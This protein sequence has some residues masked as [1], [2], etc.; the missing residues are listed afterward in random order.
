MGHAPPVP[1]RSMVS[2]TNPNPGHVRPVNHIPPSR[3]HSTSHLP[4]SSQAPPLHSMAIAGPSSHNPISR[5]KTVIGLQAP[6]KRGQAMATRGHPSLNRH[7][8]PNYHRSME[9]QGQ[10]STVFIHHIKPDRRGGGLTHL[11]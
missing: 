1:P 4:S 3:T 11:V 10:S 2:L 7:Q 8:Q 9:P 6:P 5:C